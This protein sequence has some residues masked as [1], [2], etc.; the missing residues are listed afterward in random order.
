VKLFGRGNDK[1]TNETV[2]CHHPFS[3]TKALKE[4]SQDPDRVTG[5]LCTVCGQRLR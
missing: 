5:L 4:D 3:A 1:K 2:S